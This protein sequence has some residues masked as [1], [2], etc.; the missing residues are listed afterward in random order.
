MVTLS[1]NA[2]TPEEQ[3]VLQHLIPQ[4]NDEL[5]EKINNG[6]RIQKDG[7]TLI[8]KKDL[9]TF[10]QYAEEQ[11]R[12]QLAE[13]QRKGAQAVCVQGGDIMNWAIHYFEEDSI[14]GKLYNEDGTEFM[15]TPAKCRK[16]ETSTK[17]T[18][19]PP[20][21][22]PKPQL[23]IFDMLSKD[24][25]A[26]NNTPI[27]AEPENPEPKKGSATYQHYLSI[28]KKFNDC[29]I[30]YRLGDFYEM[31]GDDA[32]MAA[33]ELNLTLTS[34][35][36]GLDERVPMAGV[37]FHAA[38]T[39]AAKLVKK[40]YKVAICEY[41]YGENTVERIITKQ[42]EDNRLVDVQTGEILSDDIDELLTVSKLIGDTPNSEAADGTPEE[43][44]LADDD[45][46]EFENDINAFFDKD[47]LYDL[48][49][50]LADR[51]DLI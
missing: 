27:K 14:E 34:R 20:E 38:D 29:V 48:F 42:P 11:A 43:S 9:T 12:K 41:L 30:F 49:D 1:L 18:V 16:V 33:K 4:A 40:N 2:T 23:N 13:N 26:Q 7:K 50:V 28:K 22:E 24:E 25:K 17:P 3:I 10:M 19:I 5:A 8:N 46:L 6:V 36:C 51:V 37:P 15:P 32:I 35:D 45:D 21:P 47:A 39:Y 31:Y 44:G